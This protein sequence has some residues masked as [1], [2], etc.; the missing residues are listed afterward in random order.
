MLAPEQR[1]LSANC[2]GGSGNSK[3]GTGP[4][5]L[6]D[7]RQKEVDKTSP[8][9]RLFSGSVGTRRTVPTCAPWW[10]R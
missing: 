2:G 5:G 3:L 7:S 1:L 10:Q 9:G 4:G 6:L 8:A